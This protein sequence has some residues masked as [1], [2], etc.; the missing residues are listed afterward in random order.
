MNHSFNEIDDEMFM[1]EEAEEEEEAEDIE[2]PVDLTKKIALP[3]LSFSAEEA[4][5]ILLL[6]WSTE[7][8]ELTVLRT[9]D[10][11]VYIECAMRINLGEEYDHGTKTYLPAKDMKL[12]DFPSA[13]SVAGL[14]F[15]HYGEDAIK[16]HLKELGIEC[17]DDD[18][19]FLLKRI[20][21]CIIHP[22][23][24]AVENP[25]FYSDLKKLSQI[26]DPIDD[27]DPIVKQENFESLIGLIIE[28][29]DQRLNW[30]ARKLLPGRNTVRKAIGDRK[31]ALPTGEIVVV[32]HYVPLSMNRDLFEKSQTKKHGV[33]Y[34]AM[35]RVVGDG[36][37][38]ALRWFGPAF[39]KLKFGGSR[40][41]HLTS[42]LQN[43]NGTGWVHPNGAVGAMDKMANAIEYLKQI[44]KPEKMM[45]NFG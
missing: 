23:D 5:A 19:P 28:Q 13:M 21:S 9:D 41:E 8:G 44:L 32:P 14:I 25:S 10:P 33:K 39:R 38:Y 37:V 17:P 34:I 45:T 3:I 31:K 16:N 24:I 22:L 43:F 42:C 35:P 15:Y 20:Y 11:E 27:P 7:C 12:K 6:R 36:G 29:F 30:I 2:L 26:L 1:E 40:D 18:I 4:I